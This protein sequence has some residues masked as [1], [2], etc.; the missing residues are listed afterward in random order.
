MAIIF[1]NYW[2]LVAGMIVGP[3]VKCLSSYIILDFRPKIEFSTKKMFK[4]LNFGGWLWGRLM[5]SFTKNIPHLFIGKNFG[6]F[7]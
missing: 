7:S 5:F 2:A 6:F 1:Q 4:L 3:L